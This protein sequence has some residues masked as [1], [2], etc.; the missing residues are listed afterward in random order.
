MTTCADDPPLVWPD[1][2]PDANE[3]YGVDFTGYLT[4]WRQP[5]IEYALTVRVR[6]AN[7]PGFEYEATTAGQTGMKEPIFPTTIAGTVT[8]GSVTWTCRAV[9]TSS[10]KATVSS[11]DWTADAAITIT[12]ESLSG[13][14]AAAFLAGGV[15]GVDYPVTVTATLSNGGEVPKVCILPVRIPTRTCVC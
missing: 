4:R 9:S 15:D 13:Q 8:D 14:S 6:V 5:G 1:K 11:V 2:H 7:R 12:S 3:D 10:L